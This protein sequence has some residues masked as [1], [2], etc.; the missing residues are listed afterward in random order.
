[1]IWLTWRQFRTSFAAVGV[2]VA[3]ALVWLAV[4]G[5]D[6]AALARR[7]TDVY[8]VLTDTDRL[9][10]YG[11]IAVLALLPAL[12]GIFWGAPLVARELET[13][14]YR[15][16][17]NQSVTRGRWLATK[18]GLTVLAVAVVT[19]L[20]TAAI[21][22]W[23]DPLD[24]AQGGQRGSLPSRM[25][26]IAF[27]MRGIVPVGYAVFALVLG[28][29]IGLV[30]RRSIPAMALTLVVYVLVQVAVPLWVRPHL[31][32]P[33]TKTETI[34]ESTIDSITADAG[35]PFEITLQT[36]DSRNWVLTNQTIDAD[37]NASALP[38]W[39]ADCLPPP[40]GAG[41]QNSEG[42]AQVTPNRGSL[43]ACLSRL[44]DEGYHQRVVYQPMSHFWPL[45][46]VETGLYLVVS[47]L[48]AGL[49]FWWIRARLS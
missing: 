34:S 35:G 44:D 3:A 23:A 38:S 46:W 25:T 45:Q 33:V 19:A 14:T 47:A 18:L 13:G 49:S 11:G 43:N 2:L 4:T 15:L 7:N 48:L 41:G 5:P 30:V 12:L 17:W 40:P 42:T 9:I 16:A 10:F 31:V 28:T 6:L 37:G 39:F 32:A 29:L 21:T 1:M 8:D 27:G 24:G 26:P 36:P 20:L 22:W